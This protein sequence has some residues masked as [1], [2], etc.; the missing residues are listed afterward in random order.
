MSLVAIS[1][2]VTVAIPGQPRIVSHTYSSISCQSIPDRQRY[3]GD[4]HSNSDGQGYSDKGYL[5]M[6]ICDSL[7]IV[8][9]CQSYY[10][11][12]RQTMIWHAYTGHLW[13]F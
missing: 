1:V 9:D 7:S 2:R 8:V 4:C 11:L 10:G 12:F 6:H 13:K 3:S 5:S